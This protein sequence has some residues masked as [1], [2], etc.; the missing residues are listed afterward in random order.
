MHK[1][2]ANAE[3]AKSERPTIYQSIHPA[4]LVSVSTCDNRVERATRSFATLVC[5]HHSFAPQRSAWLARSVYRLAHSL[6][7]L[8]RGTVEIHRYVFMLKTRFMRT[9]EILVFT[10]NT[11][12][13]GCWIACKRLK[14]K[15]DET[16]K[17]TYKLEETSSQS[18]LTRFTVFSSESITAVAW[19]LKVTINAC[20]TSTAYLSFTIIFI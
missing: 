7:S 5:S 19:I 4:D 11:P 20:T 17:K 2:P 14:M 3:K 12:I 1:P 18:F 15:V 13:A 9:I 8:P 10:R 16:K 6:H